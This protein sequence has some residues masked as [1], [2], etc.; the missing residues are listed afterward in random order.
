MKALSAIALLFLSVNAFSAQVQDCKIGDT[1]LKNVVILNNEGA[2]SIQ[3][4]LDSSK[5]LEE[6]KDLI[7]RIIY[8][9]TLSIGDGKSV[10]ELATKQYNV[11]E[12][13]C[14]KVMKSKDLI[15]VILE[16]ATDIDLSLNCRIGAEAKIHMEFNM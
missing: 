16:D 10:C 12:E 9:E 14:M 15:S 6:K 7:K 8:I 3:K 13:K 11:T 1:I 5:S 4:I 2:E